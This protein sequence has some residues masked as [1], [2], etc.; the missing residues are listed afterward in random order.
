M[1][2]CEV[3]AKNVFYLWGHSD[4]WPRVQVDVCAKSEE[5]PLKHSCDIAFTRPGQTIQKQYTS[6]QVF[7]DAEAYKLVNSCSTAV[8]SSSNSW[9]TIWVKYTNYRAKR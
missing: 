1:D 4:L 6:D 8:N 5:T 2:D 3:K 9:A 7:A